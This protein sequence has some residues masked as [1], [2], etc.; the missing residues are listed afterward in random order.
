MMK[1]SNRVEVIQIN[2]MTDFNFDEWAELYK[3]DPIEFER[4]R[5]EVIE[6]EI[7]KSSI[8]NR[9]MLRTLQTQCDAIRSV[10]NPIDATIEISKMAVK[11]LGELKTPLTQLRQICEDLYED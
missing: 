10:L 2:S 9:A 6:A 3:N 8:E 11:R 7:L 4:R 5:K 1:S